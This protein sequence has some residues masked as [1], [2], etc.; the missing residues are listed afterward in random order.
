MKSGVKGKVIDNSQAGNGATDVSSRTNYASDDL[1]GNDLDGSNNLDEDIRENVSYEVDSVQDN[2]GNDLSQGGD[3]KKQQEHFQSDTNESSNE[4]TRQELEYYKD[5]YARLLAEYVNYVRIKEEEIKKSFKS[6]NKSIILKLLDVL[7]ALDMALEQESISEAKEILE[8]VHGK[9]K[10]ILEYEGVVQ[11]GVEEGNE[12]NPNFSEVVATVEVDSAEENGKVIKVV[13]K[14]YKFA[15]GEIV[16][17]ARV[18]VGKVK[19]S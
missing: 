17:M 19:E 5:K 4:S 8:I 7:D 9:I 15:D 13:S 16:R 1:R 11:I 2:S 14:G 3:P 18:V 12:F 6:A 10:Q